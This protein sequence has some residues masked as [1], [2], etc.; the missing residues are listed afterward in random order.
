[1]NRNSLYDADEDDDDAEEDDIGEDLE[2]LRRAFMVSDANSDEITPKTNS[3]E[4]DGGGGG[5]GGVMPSDSENDDDLEMIRN[6]KSQLASSTDANLSNDPPIG[7]SLPSDSESEDDFEMI[8][9]IKSQLALPMDV[10]IPPIGLSDE[11]D[12]GAFETLRAIR[13]R[14]SAY[15]NFGEL[16]CEISLLCFVFYL[17]F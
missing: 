17:R 13:R 5:G 16:N 7:L 6:I 2:D 15:E 9:S 1:M 10:C 3:I 11:E 14:F 12:D 8:R 4:A